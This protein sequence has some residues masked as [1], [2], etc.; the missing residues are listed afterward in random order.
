MEC[1]LC[2]NPNP[3]VSIYSGDG[4][5]IKM[6]CERCSYIP[7]QCGLCEKA[8]ICP[9]ETE[10]IDLP[11]V[12]MKTIRQGNAVMQIEIKN[13]ERIEET[14][15]KS[16]PCFSEELGCLKENRICGDYV[17]RT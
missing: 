8:K 16:C 4:T 7:A 12:V 17:E 10:Q 1:F 5:F 2:G 9:F 15:K 6:L 3:E 13:P 11:K 14:C